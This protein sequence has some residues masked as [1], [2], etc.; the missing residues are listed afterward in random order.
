MSYDESYELC[1]AHRF[2]MGNASA[3]SCYRLFRL[4]TKGILLMIGAVILYYDYFLTLSKEVG[5]FWHP[6]P[7]TWASIIFF[8]NRYIALLGHVPFLY[9]VYADPCK[10]VVGP[11]RL[12][13]DDDSYSYFQALANHHVSLV[14]DMPLLAKYHGVLMLLLHFLTAVLLMM[15]VYA[16][17]FRNKWVL[18]FVA[19]EGVAAFSVA[20]WALTRPTGGAG[21][22]LQK[23]IIDTRSQT[24]V[25]FSGL[26]GF[27]FTVFALSTYRSIKLGRHNEPFLNRLFVDE[28]TQRDNA[29]I[30]YYGVT[31]SVNLVNVIVLMTADPSVD[32]A[33][34]VFANVLSVIMVS[35]LMIN[36]HDPMLHNS[37]VRGDTDE[38]DLGSRTG[39]ISTIPDGIPFALGTRAGSIF[40][41]NPSS[42]NL[43]RSFENTVLR[44]LTNPKSNEYGPF[45]GK[46]SELLQAGRPDDYVTCTFVHRMEQGHRFSIQP[47]CWSRMIA[48]ALKMVPVLELPK[49]VPNSESR[50]FPLGP[51][52]TLARATGRELLL[53]GTF[54]RQVFPLCILTHLVDG[55]IWY[56]I[57]PLALITL[58]EDL[59]CSGC[60]CWRVPVVV[61][62]DEEKREAPI[63][64]LPEVSTT[65]GA[66]FYERGE[67]PPPDMTLPACTDIAVI[68]IFSVSNR[69]CNSFV[70][71][72]FASFVYAAQIIPQQFHQRLSREKSGFGLHVFVKSL[73]DDSRLSYRGF[74]TRRCET[75][76]TC[77]FIYANVQKHH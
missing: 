70:Q 32:L 40:G 11:I 7:H 2:K 51:S 31:W 1:Q 27:D 10:T 62:G 37:T 34:P 20:C 6:G 3:A 69:R 52:L 75:E 23:S 44:V 30:V 71:N 49:L 5:R 4:Y 35:R 72:A 9:I 28:L 41:T 73:L 12:L 21:T 42:I 38:T 56:Q 16:L 25:A 19:L 48:L 76:V 67:N 22:D 18:A 74:G 39:Y 61:R 58:F 8:A 13:S 15:R 65:M 26:L 57:L 54:L 47:N 14:A 45:R 77:V 17:Y 36:L 53:L 43:S 55:T 64:Q 59:T 63:Y 46:R 50:L 68:G 29:G 33:T 66:L 24:A 60:P